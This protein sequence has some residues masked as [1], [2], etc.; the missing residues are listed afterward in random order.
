MVRA[1]NIVDVRQI[2]EIIKAYEE[3]GVMLH[4]SLSQIYEYIRDFSRLT[5]YDLRIFLSLRGRMALWA[6]GFVLL[7]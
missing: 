1:A 2:A 4:R 5:I 6:E 7:W 3:K